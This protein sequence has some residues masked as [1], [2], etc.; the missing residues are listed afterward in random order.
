MTQTPIPLF[1]KPIQPA[2]IQKINSIKLI[3]VLI[4]NFCNCLT[5]IMPNITL[6]KNKGKL[7]SV[8]FVKILILG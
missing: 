3:I 2:S 4:L 8:M 1:A 5:L 7:S 6:K